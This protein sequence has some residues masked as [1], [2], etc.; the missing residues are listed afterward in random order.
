[1]VFKDAP[2]TEEMLILWCWNERVGL[3]DREEEWV[4]HNLFYDVLSLPDLLRQS[5]VG[6]ECS[7]LITPLT[8]N[9]GLPQHVRQ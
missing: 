7:I 4:V 3:I 1:L 8:L 9:H 2:W 5:I 6:R